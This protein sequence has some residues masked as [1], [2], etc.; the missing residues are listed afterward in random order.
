MLRRAMFVTTAVV[1]AAT[2]TVAFAQS[3]RVNSAQGAVY[4][5]RAGQ[6]TP[7]KAGSVL[8]AGDRVVATSGQASIA[9]SDGCNVNVTARSMMTV[10]DASPCAGG[11]SGLVRVQNGGGDEGY[12]EGWVWDNGAW[13]WVGAGVITAVAV[14]GALSDD[15]DAPASP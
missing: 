8:Q 4:A 2:S 12:G 3:A 9:F 7:L 1:L 13:V 11:S 5:N 10:G 15:D 6:M 14:G